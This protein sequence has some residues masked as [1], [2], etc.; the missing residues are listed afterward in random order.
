MN[1][2]K[3]LFCSHVNK[4]EII[5]KREEIYTEIPNDIFD[6]FRD[7]TIDVVKE[8]CYK[9]GKEKIKEK[10]NYKDCKKYTI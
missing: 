1:F 3:Q 6:P 4:I 7:F 2:F 10:R 9:F 8:T 5:E